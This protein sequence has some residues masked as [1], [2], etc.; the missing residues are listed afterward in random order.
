MSDNRRNYHKILN[1]SANAT[2]AEIKTAFRQLARQYHPDLNPDN[3]QAQEQFR[4]ICEAYEMLLAQVQARKNDRAVSPPPRHQDAYN[5]YI[6]GVQ[7]G[8]RN[9]YTQAIASYTKALELRPQLVEAYLRRGEIY[10]RMG[11]DRAVLADCNQA[12][13]LDPN[14]AEV[15]YYLA[16]ARHRL[17][18]AQSALEAYNRTLALDPDNADAFYHRGVVQHD[19]GDRDAAIADIQAAAKH[20]QAQNDISGQRLAQATLRQLKTGFSGR[21]QRYSYNLMHQSRQKI[22]WIG[23]NL[24]LA[25]FNPGR[26]LAAVWGQIKPTEAIFLGLTWGAI[27]IIAFSFGAYGWR[28]RF[29]FAWF[30]V[31]LAGC[32]PFAGFVLLNAMTRL[33]TGRGG[34]WESDIFLGGATVVPMGL[35]TLAS[36]FSPFLGSPITIVLT[37]SL[38]S[39]T[40]LTLYS[41][42]TQISRISEA[43]AAFWTPIFFLIIGWLTYTAWVSLFFSV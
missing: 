5:Y 4:Q 17:G 8:L 33:L 2:I 29:N 13:A 27:A 3:T 1:V 19:L 14:Y 32:V 25:L 28:D 7:Q 20:Y 15:Y 30:D 12:I 21:F 9:A 24:F 11:N 16:R 18:Y 31:I 10:Y 36:G 38:T 35:L 37:T 22:S 39:Y 43:I 26:G 42:L 6:K 40:V 41:G 34:S 23:R